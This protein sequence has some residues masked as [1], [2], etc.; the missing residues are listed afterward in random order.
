MASPGE[1]YR[2]HFISQYTFLIVDNIHFDSIKRKT[3]SSAPPSFSVEPGKTLA[4]AVF[5][6]VAQHC[7]IKVPSL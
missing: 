3:G 7:E 1:N 4:N 2:E 5:I 6:V